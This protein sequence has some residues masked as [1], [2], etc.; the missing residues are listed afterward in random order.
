MSSKLTTTN[1]CSDSAG[2]KYIYPV[3]S[4]R[5]GGFS[6][7][8][9][10]NTNNSCNWRCVYCQ[11]PDLNIGVAPEID[12][13]L[14]ENELRSFLDSVLYGDFYE[15]YA[16]DQDKR[17]IKDIAIAGNGEPTTLNNF[18]DAVGLI[19]KIAH[20]FGIFPNSRFI[21]ITNGSL[22]HHSKNQD[23]LA[24]LREYGG[25]VWFKLDS[26]TCEG[27][28]FINNSGQ[29]LEA[30]IKNLILS[31]GLC[32]TK[33]QTCLIDY[34]N[35]GFTIAERQAFLTL[36]KKLREAT[37]INEV[38]LYTIARPSLQPESTRIEKMPVQVMNSFANEV[39]MLGFEVSVSY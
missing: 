27:K 5:A 32:P 9:N 14:L 29:S 16:I 11:V 3:I 15:Q 26:A 6:I 30:G 17:E 36:L 13:Q 39:R 20:E 37:T 19:G 28:R 2:L 24:R 35:Q 33:L 8:I 34:D 38:M 23:G 25:E 31:A 7:G 1:H 10:F 18:P 21:L 4:R 22:L 12:L